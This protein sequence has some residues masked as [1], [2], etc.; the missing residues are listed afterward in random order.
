MGGAWGVLDEDRL[1]RLDL[2]HPR[3]VV[4]GVVGHSG[5]EI[6]ARLALE[7]IDLRRVAE[8]VRLPLVGIAAGEAVEV[9][10]THA[11]RPT[12]EGPGLAGLE[13]RNVVVLAKP[14]CGIAVIEQHAADRRLVLGDDAVVARKARRLLGDHAETGR[15]VVAPGDQRGARGRAQRGGEHAVVAQTLVREAVHRRCRDDAA[16]GARNAEASVVGNDQQHVRR[17]LRRHDAR[18]PPGLG[19]QR[20]VLDP[21][22]ELRVGRRE[23]PAAERRGGARGAQRA[24]DLLRSGICRQ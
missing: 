7:R 23:L 9:L 8:Q 17:P 15:V 11:D 13:G 14:R 19:L 20:I 18:R 3:H 4:D 6:P 10:E 16:E 24:G 22:A 5:D 2:V 1:V 12:V 21:A